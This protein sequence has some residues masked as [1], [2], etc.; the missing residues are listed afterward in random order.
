MGNNFVQS[1]ANAVTGRDGARSGESS[2]RAQPPLTPPPT[3][4][5][6]PPAAASS[7]AQV[8]PTAALPAHALHPEMLSSIGEELAHDLTQALQ[9][10]QQAVANP[11]QYGAGLSKTHFL[12]EGLRR[13]A[14]S[15]QQMSRLAQNRVRQSHEKL[16]LPQVV[17]G[18][19]DE[20]LPESTVVG[21]VINTRF[22]PVDI[23]VDPGLL[24]SL[25]GSAL[26]WVS[27]FGT[28]IRVSTSM[29][30]WP[31]HGQLNFSSAQG[32]RTQDDIDKRSAVSQSI[33]WHLLQQ[34]ALAMGVGL[35]VTENM[36]ERSLVIEFPRTVVALEGM[37][38]M[39][40]DAGP[41]SSHSTYGSVN[42]NFVAGHQVL[43]ISQDYNFY[44][45]VREIC[46]GLSLRCEQAPSVE[47]AERICEKNPPHLIVVDDELI[48]EQYDQLMGDLQRHNPGFPSIV[49]SNGSFGFEMSDWTGTNKSRVAREQ[50]QE[51]LPAALVMELS[52]SI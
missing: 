5:A 26:D 44:K 39:E 27:E 25:V 3:N 51:Q 48:D 46:K 23:I 50:I 49:I 9:L 19:I 21:V 47:M 33:A 38:M 31:Q 34:T 37:T 10:I 36:H 40:M 16:A 17:Q 14:M 45:Q 24:V 43:L 18:V 4:I 28:I 15:M 52:R 30:H 12:V 41:A 6:S 1:L 13:K 11:R 29:K 32:V 8:H 42:S 7:N 20:R 2:L 22:K 35:E